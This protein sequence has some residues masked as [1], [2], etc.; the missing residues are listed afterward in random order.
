MNRGKDICKRLLLPGRLLTVLIPVVSFSLLIAVFYYGYDDTPI[1]YV[2]YTLSVYAL[3]VMILGLIP[4]VRK[5]VRHYREKPKHTR[6]H[7]RLSLLRSL[8]INGIYALFNLINGIHYHNV[9][10]F[11]TGIYYLVLTLIRLVLSWY[12]RRETDTEDIRK[13]LYL[14]W[15]GF[16]VCGWMLFVLNVTMTGMVVQ[17]V[18]DGM[19]SRYPE[20]MVYAVAAY[21]FYRLTTAIIRV[22]RTRDNTS[23]IDGAAQNI[24]LTAA[25]MALYSLQTAMLSAFGNDPDFQ[26]LMNAISGTAVCLLTIYG[27]L[28]MVIHGGKRKKQ[29][30][31]E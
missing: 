21:T 15:S 5:A 12:E 27:A 2:I 17:M 25:I 29:A 6:R 31:M 19:G 7:M 20:I 16:Q 18:R 30:I 4:P 11:S 1:G 10:L 24:S 28:G 26:K 8:A 3:A 9:W 23:P 13:R 14:G 22:V